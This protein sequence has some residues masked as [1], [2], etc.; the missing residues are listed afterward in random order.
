MLGKARGANAGAAAAEGAWGPVRETRREHRNEVGT[1][2]AWQGGRSL[3]LTQSEMALELV[4]SLLSSVRAGK[5]VPD[6]SAGL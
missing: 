4:E 5:G 3:D 1:G 6:P 2:C